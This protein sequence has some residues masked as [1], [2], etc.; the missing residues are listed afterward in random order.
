MAPPEVSD[1]ALMASDSTDAGDQPQPQPPPVALALTELA[2]RLAA[3]E[4]ALTAEH[5]RATAR[6]R[7]IDRLHE[8]NQRLRSDEQRLLLLPV[9]T[10]LRRLHADLRRQAGSLPAQMSIEQ[11]SDLLGSFAFSV[12]AAL[13]RCGVQVTRPEL[14]T[15]FDPRRHRAIATVPAADPEFD[16]TI[17]AVREDGYLDLAAERTLQAAAVTVYR[18]SVPNESGPPAAS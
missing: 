17:A 3:V 15:S 7:V 9:L 13:D 1:E 10:D 18:W 11:V 8:E 4:A 2:D 12:E 6:E 16:G 14:G 5:D